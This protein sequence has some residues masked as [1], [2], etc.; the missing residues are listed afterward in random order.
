MLPFCPRLPASVLMHPPAGSD[1][2][3]SSL[4]IA[5][6]YPVQTQRPLEADGRQEL[7]T[8]GMAKTTT[9][10]SSER[11]PTPLPRCKADGTPPSPNILR[12][13]PSQEE[14]EL[15]ERA[16]AAGQQHCGLA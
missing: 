14:G 13:L 8:Q 11:T 10:E 6:F 12:V 2:P 7:C 3:H 15:G 5:A 9:L 1:R 4:S 16:P